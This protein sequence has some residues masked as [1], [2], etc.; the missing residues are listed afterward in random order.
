VPLH[1]LTTAEIAEIKGAVDAINRAFPWRS[2]DASRD[3]AEAFLRSPE[4]KRM[5]GIVRG[6]AL[7]SYHEL[8]AL[9]WLGRRLDTASFSQFLAEA[10]AQ[11][12]QVDMNYLL[13]RRAR[14]ATFLEKGVSRLK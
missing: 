8:V 3:T 10:Q 13:D 6:L 4:R 9:I 2:K 7:P 11:F 1:H 14:I 12:S 5:A